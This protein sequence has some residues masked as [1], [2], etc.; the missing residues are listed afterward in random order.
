MKNKTYDYQAA[1]TSA[2]GGDWSIIGS[3]TAVSYASALRVARDLV[4]FTLKE[5]REKVTDPENP[6]AGDRIIGT[7]AVTERT[8]E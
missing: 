7:I 3:C 4:A 2:L 1:G 8:K 6:P 5:N